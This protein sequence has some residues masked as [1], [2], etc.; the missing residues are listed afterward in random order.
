MSHSQAPRAYQAVATVDFSELGDRTI[1]QALKLCGDRPEAQ[2]HVIV[3]GTE[4]DD[5]ISLPGPEER[6]AS[7]DEANEIARKHV[8]DLIDGYQRKF[9]D[10]A[11]ERV[12]VYVA[13]GYPAERII[14]LARQADADVIVMGTHGRTGLNRLLVGS[15]AEEVVRR[16][17]C[18]VFVIRP[19]D[20]WKGEK[21]PEIQEPL[22][23]GEHA[24]RPFHHAPTYHH[25]SRVSNFGSHVMPVT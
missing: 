24:L 9:G 21:L 11:M 18:G 10:I 3:V 16:A 17:P 20:F 19:A 14:A 6:L 12:A 2:L 5:G 8:A 15:V 4:E 13:T 1:E 22:K 23:A 25:V 7:V